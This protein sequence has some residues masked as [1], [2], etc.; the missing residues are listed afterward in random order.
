MGRKILTVLLRSIKIH[1]S[2]L[3]SSTGCWFYSITVTL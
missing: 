2:S 3:L 1:S